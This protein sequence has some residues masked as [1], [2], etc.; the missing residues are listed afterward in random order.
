MRGSF[1]KI[2][3]LLYILEFASGSSDTPHLQPTIVV[4][5]T[6]FMTLAAS[7]GDTQEKKDWITFLTRAHEMTEEEVAAQI[8]TP[9]VLQAFEMAKFSNFTPELRASYEAEARE[10]NDTAEL[11]RL[12]CETTEKSAKIAAKIEVARKLL[13]MNLTLDQIENATG[14]SSEDIKGIK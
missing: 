9:E 8:K 10:R 2:V 3:L 12:A 5:T 4:R 13:A 1:H 6:R 11:I 7:P 14:L